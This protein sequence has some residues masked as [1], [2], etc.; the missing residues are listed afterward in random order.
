MK[1]GSVDLRNGSNFSL[2]YFKTPFKH[3]CVGVVV[4]QQSTVPGSTVNLAV[5]RKAG[6]SE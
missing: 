5:H 3:A 1:S 6:A 4:T 2:V